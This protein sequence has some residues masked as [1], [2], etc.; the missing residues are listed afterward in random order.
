M[1]I[2]QVIA[3]VAAFV[4]LSGISVT[5]SAD[6][7]GY[8][9]GPVVNVSRIRTVDGRFDDYMKYI[10]TVWKASQEAG[11]KAGFVVSYQVQAV[12]ARTLDDPDL[13]LVV[14]YKNWAALDGAMDKNDAITKQVE[15][16]LA[17]ATAAQL[18]RAKIRTVIGSTTMQ[19]L[20]LK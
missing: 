2:K 4:C 16:S 3:A 12:E 6:D 11:I 17:A 13:L 14:T 10:G 5:A 20:Q 1:S 19:V 9:E 8:T 15:G 7:H 18:D